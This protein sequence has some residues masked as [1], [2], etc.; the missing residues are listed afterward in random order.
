MLI[1]ARTTDGP[2]AISE[3]S[4]KFQ[5]AFPS[6]WSNEAYT[7]LTGMWSSEANSQFGSSLGRELAV[8]NDNA[9][10]VWCGNT[11]TWF[12][13]GLQEFRQ[14]CILAVYIPRSLC[15]IGACQLLLQWGSRV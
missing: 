2:Y 6:P 12:R 14:N 4:S 7:A 15:H 13:F 9:P 11:V 10:L 3:L 8:K 1:I 5:G